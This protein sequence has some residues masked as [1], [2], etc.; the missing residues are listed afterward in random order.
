MT[1]VVW[2]VALGLLAA[3][4]WWVLGPPDPDAPRHSGPGPGAV[5]TVYGL[6]NE[7]RR[8]ALEVVVEQRAG[9]R[10]PERA[11]DNLPELEDP[12]SESPSKSGT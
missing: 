10:D 7:D 9:E 2:I 6:L 8:K 1:A 5:G 3:L 12:S 4:V 11:A